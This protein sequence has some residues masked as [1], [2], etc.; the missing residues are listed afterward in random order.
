MNSIQFYQQIL[1]PSSLGTGH[2]FIEKR[3][4]HNYMFSKFTHMYKDQ[5]NWKIKKLKAWCKTPASMQHR[6]SFPFKSWAKTH[7]AITFMVDKTIFRFVGKVSLLLPTLQDWRSKRI[8]TKTIW[9]LR[10]KLFWHK[11]T[12]KR[13]SQTFSKCLSVETKVIDSSL[14]NT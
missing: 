13:N 12:T 2:E 1:G 3:I 10:C 11:N 14:I 5:S 6:Q 7:I 8:C 4:Q 9:W